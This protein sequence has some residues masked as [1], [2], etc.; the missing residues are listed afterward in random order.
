MFSE[1]T[2]VVAVEWFHGLDAGGY[3]G[4]TDGQ[5]LDMP[6]DIICRP[7]LANGDVLL[8][9]QQSA[10]QRPATQQPA[11]QSRQIA[12]PRANRFQLPAR[13][14]SV[15]TLNK[16][17]AGRRL[18]KPRQSP[19]SMPGMT[20]RTA[21]GSGKKKIARRFVRL[22]RPAADQLQVSNAPSS[23]PAKSSP[24]AEA[25]RYIDL[26]LKSAAGTC[27]PAGCAQ[28]QARVRTEGSAAQRSR[29]LLLSF[30][31]PVNRCLTNITEPRL[32]P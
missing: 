16:P 23:V 2:R 29:R 9:Q 15:A 7:A 25:P 10:I 3:A 22:V 19:A 8:A 4:G 31:T 12:R 1:F 27:R 20:T 28:R 21:T 26:L 11:T 18:P 30:G 14:A 13:L 17:K 5:T 32:G 6:L 24:P